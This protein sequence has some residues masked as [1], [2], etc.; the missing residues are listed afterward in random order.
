MISSINHPTPYKGVDARAGAVPQLPQDKVEMGS[1]SP[2]NCWDPRKWG[3]SPMSSKARSQNPAD[4]ATQK[5]VDAWIAAH[6]YNQF[7][8]PMSTMYLGGTPLFDERTGASYDRDGYVI[9]HHPEA[10]SYGAKAT[11]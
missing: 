10:A 7:G 9:A 6:H 5:R 3:R 11:A 1:K 4:P 2:H 8:D